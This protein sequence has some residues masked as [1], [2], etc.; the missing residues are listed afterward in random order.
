MTF[1]PGPYPYD[2]VQSLRSL[3]ALATLGTDSLAI[4]VDWFQDNINSTEI[5]RTSYT[6]SD[7]AITTLT[8]AAQNQLNMRV[9][10]KPHVDLSNDSEH[11]RGQIGLYFNS[12]KEWDL[13]FASY[14]KMMLQYAT[15]AQKLGIAILCVGTE[16]V[17]TRDQ[18]THWRQLISQVRSVYRGELVY[19]SNCSPVADTI[20]WWDALDFIGID[21]YF[22]ICSDKLSPSVDEL[23]TCWS[24]YIPAFLNITQFY[25]K[26]IMFTEIGYT[27]T[28]DTNQHPWDVDNTTVDVNIQQR[29]YEAFF[30][31]LYVKYD[32]VAGVY[33]WAWTTDINDGGPTNIDFTPQQKPAQD[34]LQAFYHPSSSDF[35]QPST[36]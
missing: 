6:P 36:L 1:F 11:W 24:D 34:V 10:L 7:S 30:E 17:A 16:L 23:V 5:F 25:K 18:E 20:I 4:I 2:S 32:W 28:V 14:T 27:S 22:P 3:D 13:W 26:S 19:A 31:A 8:T 33:W 21:G 29:C 15:L 12:S 35:V 9:M